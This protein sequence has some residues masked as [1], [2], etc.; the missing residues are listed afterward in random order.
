V[1]VSP[2]KTY[3]LDATEAEMAQ[4]RK[5][6]TYTNT[7]AS[8]MV[9]KISKSR[10]LRE[11]KP[12]E[13]KQ[14]LDE[15]KADVKHTLVYADDKGV[16]IRPGNI[17]YLAMEFQE[18]ISFPLPD[19]RTHAWYKKPE[20]EPY[21]YQLET[22]ELMIRA[23]KSGR[24]AHAQLATGLGKSYILQLITRQMG[25]RTLIVTPS[26]S[27]FQ[28]L[29]ESFSELF[30]PNKV[31][32]LGDG[33]KKT[34]RPIVIAVAK[35]LTM[36]EPGDEHY[37][38]IR[39]MQVV[40]GDESH[41]LPAETL[42]QAFHGVLADVPYRGFVSGTQTRGDGS[43]LLLHSIIGGK[44]IDRDVAWGISN[45]YLTPFDF[46]MVNVPSTC[47]KYYSPD[48][49]RMKR[50]HFLYNDYI[51]DFTAKTAAAVARARNESSL[52][53]VEE[54]EQISLLAKRLEREGVA[55]TYVHGNT[56]PK[57]ELEAY[58]LENRKMKDE[59]AR[60]NEG[61]VKVF[62]GTKCVSTGTNFYPTHF[63]F[64]LQG[65]GSEIGTKQGVMGRATRLLAKSRYR[66][67]HAPKNVSRV[68]DFNVDVE[69]LEGSFEKR[70]EYYKE[71]DCPIKWI[72][73]K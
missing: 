50:K 25:L 49:N 48:P 64:N 12:E 56:K 26:A 60:F 63:V 54:I 10:W 67:L 34:D 5:Q 11:N 13:W 28:E 27:I 32:T 35:S 38:N 69:G 1:T 66:D 20:H 44:V 30:G 19:T 21:E 7:S 57:A 73:Y 42:D 47:P 61:K 4:L 40:L 17:P 8:F 51:M 14:K 18:Q 15:A 41:T 36:L 22:V 68:F 23:M 71:A 53:L 62:I 6:L 70:L 72:D 43:T 16:F 45:S 33:K 31:G 24:P 39:S 59:I 55:F 29:H 9:K 46:T 52:I 65:G 2:T 58:G 37:E 3:V